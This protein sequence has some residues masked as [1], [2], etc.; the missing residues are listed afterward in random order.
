MLNKQ[1]FAEVRF[2][3][4]TGYCTS[5]CTEGALVTAVKY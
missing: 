3:G 5:P 2:H 1:G 4:W